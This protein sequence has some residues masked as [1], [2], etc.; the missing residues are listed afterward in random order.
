MNPMNPQEVVALAYSVKGKEL[1][2]AKSTIADG[3]NHQVDVTIRIRGSIQRGTG[4][5]AGEMEVPQ[6][7]NLETTAAF[8]KVLR[9]L[10]I[11]KVR[12]QAA[13]RQVSN[14]VGPDEELRDVFVAESKERSSRL[15]P[16]KKPVAATAGTITTALTVVKV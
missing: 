13:L 2:L 10:K 16:I 12:L 5:P 8:C 15:D 6:S 11:G 1:D 7:V 14:D 3:S 9:L 4:K